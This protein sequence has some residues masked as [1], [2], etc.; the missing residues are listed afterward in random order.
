MS[1]THSIWETHADNHILE[2]ESTLNGYHNKNGKH[3][4][5]EKETITK[6]GLTNL[7]EIV[8]LTENQTKTFEAFQQ[9]GKNLLLHG[10]AGTGKT[11]L[12]L[13]LSL[14]EVVQKSSSKYKSI[15]II[16][17]VVPTRDIGFLPGTL[18]EKSKVYENP[19]EDICCELFGRG[20]AYQILKKKELIEFTTTSFLRGLTLR[21]CIIIVDEV[22]NMTFHELDSVIS[23]VGTNA[24]IIFAG[25]YSQT[26]L[27][28]WKDQDGL[29]DFMDI[30]QE[31]NSFEFVEFG[32]EDIVR[33]GLVKEYLLAKHRLSK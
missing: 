28:N 16:R 5:K 12:S 17:S 27:T 26:D 19:Y 31:M 3:S 10:S 20:D 7:K 24:K 33:S 25:D 18:Q 21:N 23:R 30:L 13:Y 22:N 4:K 8:P 29:L 32:I 2:L 14:L 15:V 6:L 11:F 1:K 9:R